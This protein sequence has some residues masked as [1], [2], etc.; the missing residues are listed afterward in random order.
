[1]DFWI[2]K[3]LNDWK[4]S[5]IDLINQVKWFIC[6]DYCMYEYIPNKI[7]LLKVYEIG[8]HPQRKNIWISALK[9]VQKAPR[10]DLEYRKEKIVPDKG[11]T[12]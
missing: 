8:H 12:S 11:S 2:I 10:K 7:I 3:F 6:I 5:S 4:S 1:M 9:K